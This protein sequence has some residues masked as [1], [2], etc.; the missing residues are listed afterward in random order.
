MFARRHFAY[1]CADL[2]R[3]CI[4]HF[5]VCVRTCDNLG[6]FVQCCTPHPMCLICFL[7]PFLSCLSALANGKMHTLRAVMESKALYTW[8]CVFGSGPKH[9]NY[10]NM[11][12]N[13]H[14]QHVFNTSIFLSIAGRA[15][16]Q[17]N[18]TFKRTCSK[19]REKSKR[20]RKY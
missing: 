18:R 3:A 20:I 17:R 13:V 14:S 2:S 9:H 19:P 11:V 4:T 7:E 12:A 5:Y 8:R 1:F 16:T 15:M 10:Y 6:C